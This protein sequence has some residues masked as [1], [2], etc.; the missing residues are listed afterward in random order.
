MTEP[1]D[2]C[3]VI[4]YGNIGKGVYDLLS[5][6][7]KTI[8]VDPQCGKPL[9]ETIEG[10]ILNIC[11]PGSLPNFLD[12]VLEYVL[13]LKPKLTIVHS[14]VIPGMTKSIQ[15]LVNHPVVFSPVIGRH[16]NLTKSIKVF[17]KMFAVDNAK[18]YGVLEGFLSTIPNFNYKIFDDTVSLEL[19]KLCDTTYYGLCIAWHGEVRDMC[20]DLGAKLD[21]IK[22]YN[23]IYNENYEKIGLSELK[24]PVL[25]P[26]DGP[27]GGTCV[28][29]NSIMLNSIC[30]SDLISEIIKKY[31]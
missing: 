6:Y 26:P 25:D 12:V 11:I 17:T 30:E 28:I 2:V 1:K 21:I 31:S 8:A 19:A 15:H 3:Y 18:Y 13:K 4:G 22:D 5:P 23:K 7:F 14:T 16:N 24:R 9:T 20:D 27:I 10:G 29:P